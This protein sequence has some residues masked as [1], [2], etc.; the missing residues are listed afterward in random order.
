MLCHLDMTHDRRLGI[1]ASLVGAGAAIWYFHDVA[2]ATAHRGTVAF[3]WVPALI[4]ATSIVLALYLGTRE[5]RG[6]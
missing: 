5:G 2:R 1:V 3:P 4:G 6:D